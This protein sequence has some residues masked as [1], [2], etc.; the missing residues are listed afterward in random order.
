MN[1]FTLDKFVT[2]VDADD[3][4]NSLLLYLCQRTNHN[5]NCAMQ[6]IN[7]R[8]ILNS[9]IPLI[10]PPNQ[11]QIDDFL[12]P[13]RPYTSIFDNFFETTDN[14]MKSA[15]VTFGIRCKT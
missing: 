10:F 2:H 6:T 1:F 4:L 3:L 12:C 7:K 15:T 11:N 8:K 13:Y 9:M 14:I 5:Y